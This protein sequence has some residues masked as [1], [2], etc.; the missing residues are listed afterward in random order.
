LF[1]HAFI[2]ETAEIALEV[3]WN[4]VLCFTEYQTFSTQHQVKAM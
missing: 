2:Q 1:S 3:V 4:W